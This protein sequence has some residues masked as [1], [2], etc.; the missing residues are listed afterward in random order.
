MAPA[1]YK[2]LHRYE[3]KNYIRFLTFGC[4]HGLPLFNND[5]I[6]DAFLAHLAHSRDHQNFKLYAWVIMPDH[7]HLLLRPDLPSNPVSEILKQI[8]GGFSNL[9]C[10]H[11]RRA[12][13]P[14]LSRI[15][16]SGDKIHFWQVGGGYDRNIISDEEL[17]EKFNYIHQNPI[18]RKLVERPQ[19]WV[20][21][22]YSV[23]MNK[24]ADAIL[25][26]DTLPIC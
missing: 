13:A 21:S 4:Y 14:I 1:K 25:T 18:R 6:K 3:V 15:K 2:S 12:N 11:W 8:K 7:V 19:D 9:V 20:W 24:T 16:D 26:A 10:G 17:R 22:S 5:K 23:I